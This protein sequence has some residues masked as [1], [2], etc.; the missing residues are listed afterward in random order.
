M[1]YSV[2]IKLEA[3]KL[4]LLKYEVGYFF[5]PSNFLD[6]ELTDTLSSL[7]KMNQS[8]NVGLI[9]RH[10][11]FFLLL[12]CIYFRGETAVREVSPKLSFTFYMKHAVI[13]YINWI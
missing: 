12:F 3:E 13:I 4:K 5:T 7:V 1:S 2:S 11:F 10:F 9:I 6:L 8:R